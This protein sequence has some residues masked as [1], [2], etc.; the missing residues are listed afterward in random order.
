MD[1]LDALQG[2]RDFSLFQYHCL[3]K[4]GRTEEA[5]A[6]LDQFR[7][8]FL[9]AVIEPPNGQ[10]MERQI[11]DLFAPGTFIASLLQDMYAAEVYLSLDA[12][13]DG[14]AF[15]GYAPEQADSEAA[16]LSRA[17]TLGQILLL[18]KKYREYADLTTQTIAPLLIKLLKAVPAGG[19][20]GFLDANT[21]TQLVAGLAL[22]PLGAPEFLSLL[23]EKQLQ[24]L[25]PRWEKLSASSEDVCR[26]LFDMVL[27][28]CIGQP[29]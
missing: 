5:R 1:Y 17:I 9:P 6:K 22:S 24:G 16:R 15:F 12:A 23:P 21:L 28:V 7:Q 8:R 19:W 20:R 25:L 2:P 10:G 4:L 13:E 18:E 26:P 27:R 29:V 3:T 14:E 11:H